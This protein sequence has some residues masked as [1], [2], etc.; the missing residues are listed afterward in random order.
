MSEN[1]SHNCSSCK[2]SCN[3]RDPK[4]LLQEPHEMSSIK[5]V[6][7]VVSGKGGVG[8]IPGHLPYGLLH[9]E[10]GISYRHYGR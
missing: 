6:I 7:A 3:D 1:C 2:E 5:N 9:A 4:S 10:K 8:E